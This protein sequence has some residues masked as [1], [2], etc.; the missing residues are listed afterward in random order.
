MTA[1]KW[2]LKQQLE[3]VHTGEV[4]WSRFFL[5]TAPEW[6][7][8]A[9]MT[10]R[11]WKLPWGI[12]VADVDQQLQL[13]AFIAAPNWDEGRA[14]FPNFVLWEAINRTGKW[15]HTQRKA[16]R[17]DGS[18]PSRSAVAFSTI[19]VELEVPTDPL[20]D[21]LSTRAE[22]IAK[23]LVRLD[24]ASQHLLI[25]LIAADGD[26]DAAVE[27]LWSDVTFRRTMR[28]DSIE[29]ARCRLDRAVRAAVTK[30]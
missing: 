11:R 20:A 26:F 8:L 10:F 9:H 29:D 21:S 22:A 17:R 19:E 7:R 1:A 30:H 3:R 14:P 12:E 6:R 28:L 2:T 27:D 15:L 13:E 25:A 4:S 18:A 23:A 16:K 5:E 24:E